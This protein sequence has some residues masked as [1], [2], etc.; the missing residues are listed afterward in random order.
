MELSEILCGIV[1]VI[2]ALYYYLTSTFNFWK[3]RDVQGPQP[4]PG[5]GNLKDVLLAKIHLGDYVTKIYN[6]YKNEALIGIF[7][8]KTPI[9]IVKDLDLI[10]DVLIKDFTC[11]S[12]RGFPVTEKVRILFYKFIW[13]T[14]GIND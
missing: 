11:F 12:D 5:F 4:I 1:A 10:K 3:S 9:L 7:S 6:E 13:S 8:R 14:N 2:I